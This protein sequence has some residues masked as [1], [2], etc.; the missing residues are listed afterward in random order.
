MPDNTIWVTAYDSRVTLFSHWRAICIFTQCVKFVLKNPGSI[1][2]MNNILVVSHTNKIVYSFAIKPL[3]LNG[4]MGTPTWDTICWL[5]HGRRVYIECFQKRCLEADDQLHSIILY[6]TLFDSIP[7]HYTPILL[8]CACAYNETHRS[9]SSDIFYTF[10]HSESVY[11][12]HIL[13]QDWITH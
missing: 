12:S 8:R 3:A 4:D 1:F 2:H 13:H 10:K 11:D 5:I 6:S 7:S 9:W